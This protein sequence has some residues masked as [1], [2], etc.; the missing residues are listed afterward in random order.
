MWSEKKIF[1]AK[2][3]LK[4]KKVIDEKVKIMDEKTGRIGGSKKW[5]KK[6]GEKV[7]EK[8]PEKTVEEVIQNY[9]RRD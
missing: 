4:K 9:G 6:L 5:R 3:N 7:V 8:M 2:S 1:G